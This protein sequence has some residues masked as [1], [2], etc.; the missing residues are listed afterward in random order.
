LVQVVAAQVSELVVRTM[1]AS[2]RVHDGQ[3]ATP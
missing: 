1:L 2:C 3:F